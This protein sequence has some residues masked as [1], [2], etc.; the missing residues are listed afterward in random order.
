MTLWLIIEVA[1]RVFD[2]ANR[3]ACALFNMEGGG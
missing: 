2:E 1:R 3:E